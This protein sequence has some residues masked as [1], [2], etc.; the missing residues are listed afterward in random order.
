MIVLQIYML[1]RYEISCPS[2]I[3][4]VHITVAYKKMPYIYMVEI[5]DIFCLYLTLNYSFRTLNELCG[6]YM[7][8][9]YDL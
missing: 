9:S 3:L 2:L 1:A 8:C 4:T 6:S 7:D 5:V